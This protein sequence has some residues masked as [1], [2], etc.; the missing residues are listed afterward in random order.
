MLCYFAVW[1]LIHRN[2][3][4]HFQSHCKF[5]PDSL[6]QCLLSWLL[7]I[8]I[9]TTY[10]YFIYLHLFILILFLYIYIV[11]MIMW[12]FLCLQ[13]QVLTWVTDTVF[14][15]FPNVTNVILL[16]KKS[17]PFSEQHCTEWS[18]MIPRASRVPKVLSSKLS[19]PSS[20]TMCI[21]PSGTSL[22][23]TT[24]ERVQWGNNCEQSLI[25]WKARVEG[26]Y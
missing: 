24:D 4:H 26:F 13:I 21:C 16:S 14:F 19:S 25:G 3:K 10:L 7:C 12:E 20:Q 1:I 2:I 18:H 5:F 15:F 9:Y 8:C 6:R 11:M 17:S 22:I 23:G